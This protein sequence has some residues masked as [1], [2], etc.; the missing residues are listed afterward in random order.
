MIRR[1][2]GSYGLILNGWYTNTEYFCFSNLVAV[3]KLSLCRSFSAGLKISKGTKLLSHRVAFNPKCSMRQTGLSTLQST[4]FAVLIAHTYSIINRAIIFQTAAAKW[5]GKNINRNLCSPTLE[6][7]WD[8][9]RYS[10][11]YQEQCRKVI[12][13]K[14]SQTSMNTSLQT[15]RTVGMPPAS[16]KSQRKIGNG[17][18]SFS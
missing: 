18:S 4:I 17:M 3:E 16:S 13:V 6:V 14:S 5:E 15:R 10:L 11:G 2:L 8:I 9:L 7:L 12:N 1:L